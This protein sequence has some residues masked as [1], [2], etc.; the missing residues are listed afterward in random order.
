LIGGR[1]EIPQRFPGGD[2]DENARWLRTERRVDALRR[3]A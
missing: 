1:H 2:E 3:W